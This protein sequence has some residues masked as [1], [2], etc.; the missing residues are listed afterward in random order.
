VELA[1][2]FE[3]EGRVKTERGRK[4]AALLN[5][6]GA[7]RRVAGEGGGPGGRRGLADSQNLGGKT[8]LTGQSC[9][10]KRVS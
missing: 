7:V 1:E 8:Y 6:S 3:E 9:I 2:I 4:K 5:E 10:K